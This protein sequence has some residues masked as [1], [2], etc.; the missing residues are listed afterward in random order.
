MVYI[1]SQDPLADLFV[2]TTSQLHLKD[3]MLEPEEEVCIQ[4]QWNLCFKETVKP[5]E[6]L[7]FNKRKSKLN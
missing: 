1:S 4:L 5:T 7:L 2:F 3:C 6:H